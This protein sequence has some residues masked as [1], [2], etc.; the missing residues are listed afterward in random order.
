MIIYKI[1]N[2]KNNRIYIGQTTKSAKERLQK[3]IIEARCQKNGN[4][5]EN[6]FHSAINKYGEDNFIIEQID[7]ANSI[8]ELNDKEIYWINFYNCTSKEFGYNLMEGGKSG[9]KSLETRQK[10]SEKKKENWQDEE[11]ATKMRA[12]LV[13]ATEKWVEICKNN[14]EIVVCKYCGKEFSVPPW[15]AKRR[16]YCSNN[17]ANTVNIQ[18]ATQV[19]AENKIAKTKQRNELLRN[20]AKNWAKENIELINTCPNRGINTHFIS[21]QQLIA[22]EYHIS[23][24]RSICQAICGSPNK[25]DL[26]GYLQDLVKIYAEQDQN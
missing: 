16:K 4:R 6:Y 10:I 20:T 22:Q 17:C 21:L 15:E 1:T 19:A 3:H 5:P 25:T 14:E 24:W 12:G 13:K 7:E 23:D 18:K 11:L 2:T 8:E 9:I 26:L